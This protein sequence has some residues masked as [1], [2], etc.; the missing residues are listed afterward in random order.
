MNTI[1]IQG[2]DTLL[3][4]YFAARWLRVPT[5]RVFF[6]SEISPSR[7]AD[8]VMSAARQMFPEQ[9]FAQGEWHL[10]E[11]LH[12]M[13]PGSG[14]GQP[15]IVAGALW[16]FAS[17]RNNSIVSSLSEL[18]ADVARTIGATEVNY[19]A[20]DLDE[21][22]QPQ[23]EV[24]LE[25]AKKWAEAGLRYRL[26]TTSLVLAPVLPGVIHDE[27]LAQ[28]LS[29]VF[30]VKSEIQERSPEY[31]DFH[32]LRFYSPTCASINVVSASRVAESLMRIAESNETL[33]SVHSIR[34]R[35]NIPVSELCEDISIAYDLSLLPTDDRKSF[36]AIDR[37]FQERLAGVEFSSLPASRETL[38]KPS[39]RMVV[40]LHDE[41]QEEERSSV[42]ESCRREQEQ[43]MA[44]FK[45][46]AAGFLRNL[47]RRAVTRDG[48]DLEY[49]IGGDAGTAVLVLNALGQGLECWS[50]LLYLLSQNH[51]VIIWEP[52]GTV[53]PPAPFGLDQQ[54]KD[55]AVVLAQEGISACHLIGW[56]TGPKVAVNF[57]LQQPS[58]VRSMAFLNTSL[59]C[60]ESPEEL[61][62]PYEQNME[63]LCRML[64]RKPGMASSVRNTLNSRE[65]QDETE[66]L[67]GSDRQ[68]IG[69]TVLSLMNRDLRQA[70]LT[71]FRTEETTVNYAHQ[72]VDFWNHD[73]R[74]QAGAVKV[75]VLLLSAEYDQVAMPAAS[76]QA[77]ALFPSVQHVHVA[78]ATH[79]CL[80]DRAELVARLLEK[81][82]S[83]TDDSG[84][85][86]P[87]QPEPTLIEV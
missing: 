12:R 87:A 44:E 11:R 21:T 54:V 50:R 46:L 51:R 9:G 81:F 47:T 63:S 1:V 86:R 2:I 83:A 58:L 67:Q 76:T 53:T 27:V 45:S 29:A 82:F 66:I 16:C 33:N 25:I 40:I 28:F 74:S 22:R 30:A 10:S 32:A 80:Y 75:P 49:Y 8:L 3:G 60:N 36:N 65:E 5:H 4:S 59:K 31:F 71:P 57:Y 73:I 43:A 52:R 48:S 62:S 55:V 78:G 17:A 56:C 38:F 64:V 68:E 79:Y 19:V 26:V 14:A 37:T 69:E 24:L 6:S 72:L 42:V 41:L 35:E 13:S 70:V 7:A 77:A 61:N 85:R 23:H 20:F 18:P 84:V 34:S 15:D 39:A